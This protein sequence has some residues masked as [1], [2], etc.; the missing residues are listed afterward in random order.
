VGHA[1]LSLLAFSVAVV[2]A[3]G[4]GATSGGGGIFG[5]DS[6][7][8]TGPSGGLISGDLTGEGGTTSNSGGAGCTGQASDYVYVLSAENDLYRFAPDQ[9]QFTKIGTL[10]CDTLLL[11]NSMAVDRNAVAY[12][13]YVAPDGATGAI[14]QV[15]TENASCTGPV[16]TLP[17]GWE[18]VGMGYS[19]NTGASTETLYV[20]ATNGTQGLGLVDFGLGT[21]DPVGPFTGTLQGRSAELTGTGDGRLFGFFATNPVEVD[22]IDKM[23]GS[24]EMPV[25][26]TG[27]K[28]PL[29]WAFSFWGSHF[30]LYT[31]QDTGTGSDVADYDPASG[32]VDPSYM[33]GIGFEIVGAGVSTCAPVSAP[34]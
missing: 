6:G 27:L 2:F 9:K 11:P 20:A 21:V 14:F 13:N 1:L 24:T 31:S 17:V 16:M 3:V 7:S 4:C 32:S 10:A 34:Q 30:Y 12:V 29:A 18:R 26:M 28:T 25:R 15:S 8:G 19:T 22:E 23:N 5:G 33:Q